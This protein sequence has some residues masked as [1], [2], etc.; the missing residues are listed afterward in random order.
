MIG[1]DF[2]SPATATDFVFL[3]SEHLIDSLLS[4]DKENLKTYNKKAS[5]INH[6]T[7]PLTIPITP[8]VPCITLCH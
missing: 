1:W 2:Y 5:E 7:P 6:L 4:E 8:R 3:L